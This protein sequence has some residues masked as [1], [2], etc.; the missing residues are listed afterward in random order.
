MKNLF[1]LSLIL[2]VLST[3]L[4][5]RNKDDSASVLSEKFLIS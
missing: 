4:N 5:G 3:T 1:K 2:L